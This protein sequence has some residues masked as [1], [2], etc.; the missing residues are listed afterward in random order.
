MAI[1]KSS[2]KWL[3][4]KFVNKFLGLSTHGKETRMV[5]MIAVVRSLY[6]V[7]RTSLNNPGIN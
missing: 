2:L 1:S 7:L 3:K 4:L 6:A 5:L